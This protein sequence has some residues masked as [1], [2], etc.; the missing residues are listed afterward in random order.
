MRTKTKTKRQGARG[1][2][3]KQAPAKPSKADWPTTLPERIRAVRQAL[4]THAKPATAAD[5]AAQF[6]RANKSHVAELLE[7]LVAVGQAR[8]TAGGEY[9]P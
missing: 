1:K 4:T 5:I 3:K 6:S 2:G 7:T 9:A 8:V